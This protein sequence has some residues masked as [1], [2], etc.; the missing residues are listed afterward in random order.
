MYEEGDAGTEFNKEKFKSP[1][2]VDG[3]SK[4]H[5]GKEKMQSMVNNRI[6]VYK[7]GGWKDRAYWMS[8]GTR[9]GLDQNQSQDDLGFRC[10][11]HRV[12]SSTS[13]N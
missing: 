10:A 13:G 12:G 3:G 11:M 8:P 4:N 5:R 6:H 1:A 7:G 2:Y 9:R